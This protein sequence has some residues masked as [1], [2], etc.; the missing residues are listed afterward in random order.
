M[1]ISP[2]FH[3]SLDGSALQTYLTSL[4]G[5]VVFSGVR[6]FRIYQHDACQSLLIGLYLKV[7]R[8]RHFHLFPLAC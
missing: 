8:A 7:A 3:V 2:L 1:F 6:L 5:R 4:A